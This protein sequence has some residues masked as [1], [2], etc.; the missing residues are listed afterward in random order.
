MPLPDSIRRVFRFVRWTLLAFAALLLLAG[1]LFAVNGLILA[2]RETPRTGHTGHPPS[3]PREGG[4]A[5]VRVL[6]YNIAKLFV[7]R[8]GF[9]FADPDEVRERLARVAEIVK[10]H[11]PDFVFLSEAVWECGLSP[12]N[13]VKTLAEATGMHAWATGENYNLGVPGFRIAGGNAILSRYPFE[14]LA[15]SDLAG[16]RPFWVSRNN[17]R[18]LLCATRI[19]GR[20]VVLGAVHNDSFR[21]MNNLAQTWQILGKL[22]DRPTILAGDFNAGPGQPSIEAI[23]RSGRFAG[24]FDGPPTFP[25]ERPEQTID[26]VFGPAD[27]TVTEHRTIPTTVSDHRPVFTVFRLPDAEPA[28]EPRPSGTPEESTAE[29]GG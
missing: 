10:V 3:E 25:A 28:P 8:G 18:A 20:R 6:S 17:R 15:N 19:G 9:R 24:V 11:R 21:P 5:E 12:V 4:A 23:R 29:R 13:Q 2:G 27:W 1:G 7:H 22:G 26:F 14:P 16:R